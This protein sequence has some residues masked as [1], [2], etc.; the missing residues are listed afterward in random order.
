MHALSRSLSRARPGPHNQP[1]SHR[2]VTPCAQVWEMVCW[3]R[4]ER[5]APNVRCRRQFRTYL[6]QVFGGESVG[7]AAALFISPTT[8]ARPLACIVSSAFILL[9]L[10]FLLAL[11]FLCLADCAAYELTSSFTLFV[12]YPSRSFAVACFCRLER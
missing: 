1:H 7:T 9:L 12:V 3:G 11:V 10:S 4:A 2:P 8:V 5:P 6:S